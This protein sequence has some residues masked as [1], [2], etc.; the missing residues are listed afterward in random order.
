MNGRIFCGLLGLL[1]S[2]SFPADAQNP[3]RY[4]RKPLPAPNFF[5]PEKA[6]SHQEKLPPFNLPR[7]K[8]ATDAAV[9]EEPIGE[10]PHE[11]ISF[12]SADNNTE[13]SAEAIKEF[14]PSLDVSLP[15]EPLA[16][17]DDAATPKYKQEY[18]TY[19]KDLK[20]I[21]ET[22]QAPKNPELEEDLKKLDSEDRLEVD[23]EGRIIN[24]FQQSQ[25]IN[26][27]AYGR[28]Y[29]SASNT[30]IL[31]QVEIN[32]SPEPIPAAVPSS[33]EEPQ[34]PFATGK[35][36][37]EQPT[38]NA[39]VVPQPPKTT[40]PKETMSQEETISPETAAYFGGTNPFY[41]GEVITYE[42]E[43]EE[44][45]PEDISETPATPEEPTMPEPTFQEDTGSQSTNYSSEP[46]S[47]KTRSSGSRD[48]R[49]NSVKS[50][51]LGPNMVR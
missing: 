6:L 36:L 26:P 31:E 44:E 37:P 23:E 3:G 18:D 7:Q 48:N 20:V 10:T 25:L 4:V 11:A 27:M 39:P 17:S 22:G 21:E 15:E 12:K 40:A 42:T 35:P 51:N 46:R 13:E 8:Q 29:P 16:D 5:V 19:I 50:F 28:E 38:E 32:R 43:E 47:R 9:A 49:N 33:E 14:N 1:V 41:D 34:N 2:T 45:A 24:S 30:Q